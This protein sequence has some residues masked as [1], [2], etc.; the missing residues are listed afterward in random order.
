MEIPISKCVT[1]VQGQFKYEENVEAL[2]GGDESIVGIETDQSIEIELE[3]A[4]TRLRELEKQ[5]EMIRQIQSNVDKH[6]LNIS[7]EDKLQADARSIY[8]GNVEYGATSEELAL[9]FNLCGVVKRVTI[10]C[11][12]FDGHPK[13]FAYIEFTDTDS[14]QMALKL[15][16]SLFRG[17]QLK[18]MPKRTNKP[19]ISTTDRAPRRPTRGRSY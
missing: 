17:R 11:N 3:V 10:L 13:G 7:L 19:G 16:E 9:H 5:A 4:K 12:K 6:P 14:I 2:D 8:V 1:M 15:D 18:V